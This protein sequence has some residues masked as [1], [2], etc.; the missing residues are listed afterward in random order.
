MRKIPF[1]RAL[2]YLFAT[3]FII[4]ILFIIKGSFSPPHKG[5]KAPTASSSPTP[6]LHLKE[7]AKEFQKINKPRKGNNFV[8]KEKPIGPEKPVGPSPEVKD[9]QPNPRVRGKLP[10]VKSNPDSNIKKDKTKA[11]NR[12]QIQDPLEAAINY[13]ANYDSKTTPV[14]KLIHQMYGTHRLPKS[15]DELAEKFRKQENY[16]HL[17]W[18]DYDLDQFVQ[19]FHPSVY[20]LYRTIPIPH[21]RSDLTRYLLLYSFGG[22]ACD[23]EVELIMDLDKWADEERFGL[24][25]GIDSVGTSKSR[26]GDDEREVKFGQFIISAVPGHEV[27]AKA[28]Y[29]SQQRMKKAQQI[30]MKDQ[31]YLTGGVLWT[32][33]L[34]EILTTK[35]KSLKNFKDLR[36]PELVDDIYIL[37]KNAFSGDKSS[38]NSMTRAIKQAGARPLL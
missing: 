7:D 20:S 16:T 11:K 21:M 29:M 15:L 33:A 8:V 5:M 36:S 13:V 35:G 37:P 12:K 3:L 4:G 10:S 26:W 9:N 25:V 38:V 22:T 17:L 1:R 32:D 18:S 23:I 27:L 19:R 24:L 34:S 2:R 30:S 28:L 6:V 31:D 14:P